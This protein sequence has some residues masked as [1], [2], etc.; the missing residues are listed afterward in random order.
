MDSCKSQPPRARRGIDANHVPVA[1]DLDLVVR[2]AIMEHQCD[3]CSALLVVF[4]SLRQID[5]GKDVGVDDHKS[6]LIPEIFCVFDPAACAQ[7]LRLH[8]HLYVE[9]EEIAPAQIVHHLLGVM[10]GVGNDLV[11]PVAF[12]IGDNP[13]DQRLVDDRHERFGFFV[14]ERPQPGAEACSE[15]HGFHENP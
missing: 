15:N 4:V 8:P 5:V 10:V 9:S 6:I 14:R 7:D 11:Y 13:G 3:E 12:E 2:P 1:V